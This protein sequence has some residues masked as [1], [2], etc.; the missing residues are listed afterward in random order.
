MT[1]GITIIGNT[2]IDVV[3]ADTR[4]PPE[5]GTEHVVSAVFIRLGR[6]AGNFAVRCAGLN[7]PTT[8]VSRVGD[9]TSVTVLESELRLPSLEARLLRTP[10][11]RSGITVAVEPPGRDRAFL[12]SL[13]AMTSMTPDDNT[14]DMPSNRYVALAGYF[15]LPGMRGPAAADLFGRAA[16]S[17][18]QTVLDTGWPPEGWSPAT[19]QEVVN[20]LAWWTSSCPTTT[21]C[22]A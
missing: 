1:D 22:T 6:S 7:C 4:D 21:D 20:A 15:L 12:S 11:R 9:D 18:A 19:R 3:V 5:P 16:L 14:D 10:G 13:G 8:L 17:G 2:N